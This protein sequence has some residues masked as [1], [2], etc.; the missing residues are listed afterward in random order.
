MIAEILRGAARL[1]YPPLCG[2]CE[3]PLLPADVDFCE[4]CRMRLLSDPHVTCTRCSGTVGE[5]TDTTEG[6]PNCRN[7]T[8][9][10]D[11]SLRLGPF[12]DVLRDAIL[13][14]KSRAGETLAELIGLT[15]AR[16]QRSL[17]LERKAD[18][19][20]PVPLHWI[21]RWGRGYNQSRTLAEAVAKEL[22][23]PAKPGW[24]GRIRATPSQTT[25]SPTER[26]T[27][28]K[29]AF[30]VSRRA[31]LKDKRV[32]LIDDVMT[33]GSTASEAAKALKAAGAGEVHIAVL[34][35]N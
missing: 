1:V 27:N 15:W 10:F 17:L 2:L 11:S 16:H 26:R 29:D 5:H 12:D 34:G 21:R 22:R 32:L 24:L 18:V 30:R 14:M 31:D 4:T 33:T 7:D 35:H 25:L 19:V 9:H 23:L 8:F 28:L 6:C 3:S 20:I 13:R